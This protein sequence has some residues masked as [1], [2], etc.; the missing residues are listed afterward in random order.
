MKKLLTAA[1]LF[2]AVLALGPS[3]A[4]ALE[5]PFL[6]ARYAGGDKVNLW[7]STVPTATSY[8]VLYG[9]KDNPTAHGVTL[10]NGTSYTVGALFR[11]TSYVFTVKA[12]LGNEVSAN[13]NWVTVWVGDGRAPVPAAVA[14]APGAVGSQVDGKIVTPAVYYNPALDT[15]RTDAPLNSPYI[16]SGKPGVGDLNLR[17]SRGLTTGTV[18]LHWNEPVQPPNSGYYNIVYTDDPA[19]EK[20]GVLN[21]PREARSYVIGGLVSGKRYWVWMSTRDGG[22]T[23]WVSDLAR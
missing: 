5:T 22:R 1:L 20:W 14:P 12:V 3:R 13:S 9:P 21:V 7:W 6:S 15:M 10:G 8:Q 19:V 4:L 16:S 2:V 23:P 11:N 17:T 18:I